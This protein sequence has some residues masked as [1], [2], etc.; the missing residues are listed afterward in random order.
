MD[1][2]KLTVPERRYKIDEPSEEVKRRVG[3]AALG[4]TATAI[5]NI[6]LADVY[7]GE[8]P[9]PEEVLNR[10]IEVDIEF[11]SKAH[12]G[13]LRAVGRTTDSKVSNVTINIP[14][15]MDEQSTARLLH[16]DE[17]IEE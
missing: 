8:L 6:R 13:G 10:E 5:L 1:M 3:H 16:T 15:N 14:G 4:E 2:N 9:I 17:R 11:V 7:E 12:A